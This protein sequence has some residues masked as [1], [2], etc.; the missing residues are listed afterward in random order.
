MTMPPPE[1]PWEAN[2]NVSVMCPDCREVPANIVEEFSSGDMVCGSCGLVLGDRIVDTRSEWRTFSNDDQA[3]DDPSRVGDAANPFLN[4]AQLETTISYTPGGAG[5]ELHRAQ[6]KTAGDKSTKGLLAAYKEIGAFCDSINIQKVVSDAAKQLFKI[7]DDHKAFKGKP[8]EAII[9]GCI[10]IACR[11]CQVPRTF[12]E[13]FALTKVPKKEIGRV[14]KALEKFFAA[15]DSK[16]MD[17]IT[18]SGGIVDDSQQY[19]T[20]SSTKATELM[21]RY[22]NNLNLTQNCTTIAQELADRA[23]TIGTLAGRSPI[24]SA[25]ACI[26]MVS[27]LMKQPKTAK[28]ISTIAGVSDGTIRNAYKHL[29]TDRNKLIDPK[30]VENGKGDISALPSS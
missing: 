27:Y 7:V 16:K 19:K 4:G 25:A 26:Y 3:G 30:W 10:F 17:E 6:N 18:K 13:I 2:H 15:Q 29:Y 5:R 12:R 21:I 1:K 24:S 11:Q 14:F 20:T 8:Q 22:C 28:E 23:A 9:A